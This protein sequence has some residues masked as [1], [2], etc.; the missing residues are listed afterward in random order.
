MRFYLLFS[1]NVIYFGVCVNFETCMLCACVHVCVGQPAKCV[2]AAAA[3]VCAMLIKN[4]F[5][6]FIF[7]SLPPFYCLLAGPKRFSLFFLLHP[8][9][10]VYYQIANLWGE[11]LIVLCLLHLHCTWKRE[12]RINN[13]YLWKWTNEQRGS[14]SYHVAILANEHCAMLTFV[15]SFHCCRDR[16]VSNNR[17]YVE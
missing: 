12:L 5:S 4:T 13:K 8:L 14:R 10:P 7:V 15:H 16:S 3:Y 17:K 1:V 6:S 11:R 9:T 2:R